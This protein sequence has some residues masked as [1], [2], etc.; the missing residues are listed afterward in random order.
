MPEYLAP[1][2]YV[3]EV[4]G[5]AKPIEGVSTSTIS[6]VGAQTIKEI[7]R[8]INQAGGVA[9]GSRGADPTIALLELIAWIGDNLARQQDRF[10]AE[11]ALPTSRLLTAALAMAIKNGVPR[12]NGGIKSVHF[13]EGQMLTDEGLTADIDYARKTCERRFGIVSGFG[14]T[15]DGGGDDWVITVDPGCALDAHGRKIV[16]KT[17]TKLVL[18]STLARACVIARAKDQSRVSVAVLASVECEAIVVS[19]PQ[20]G[21]VTLGC[22][23]KPA[24]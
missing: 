1:G 5:R 13:F 3:T 8:L 16:L 17:T 20:P 10:A 12:E 23:E 22:V 4:A 9:A 14:I 6:I 11:A 7:Q 15:A 24:R 18:P 21:D 2:V 19:E